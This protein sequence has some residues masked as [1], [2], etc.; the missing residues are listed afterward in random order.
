M[1]PCRPPPLTLCVHRPPSLS[2]PTIKQRQ[3]KFKELI[4]LS[5]VIKEK[6]TRPVSIFGHFL[7]VLINYVPHVSTADTW[8][9]GGLASL[10]G[11]FK[12][13]D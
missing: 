10:G 5:K 4:N 8:L 2:T 13:T 1:P 12:R 7:T 9:A 11:S 6:S 3:K